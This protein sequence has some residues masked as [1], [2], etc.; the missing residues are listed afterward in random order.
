MRCTRVSSCK[1]DRPERVLR[2]DANDVF[3]ALHRLA[4]ATQAVPDDALPAQ[5]VPPPGKRSH[6][7]ACGVSTVTTTR[8]SLACRQP[9]A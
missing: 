5:P 2:H 1:L 3:P 7:L 8:A 4:V 9:I 6:D